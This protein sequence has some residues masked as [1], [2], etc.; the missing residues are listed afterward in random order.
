M[1]RCHS[2]K[3][4]PEDVPSWHGEH[5]GTPVQSH[6]QNAVSCTLLS[7]QQVQACHCLGSRWIKCPLPT[8]PYTAGHCVSRLTDWKSRAWHPRLL[9]HILAAELRVPQPSSQ[10]RVC[11]SVMLRGAY[12]VVGA[13]GDRARKQQ[14]GHPLLSA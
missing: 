10:C 5:W 1:H 11:N 2:E 9:P 14:G 3:L 4:S 6:P 7:S 12:L 13:L 8:P